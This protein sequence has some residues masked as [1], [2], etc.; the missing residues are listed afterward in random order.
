[1]LTALSHTVSTDSIRQLL[2]RAGGEFRLQ[3]VQLETRPRKLEDRILVS[4]KCVL[5]HYPLDGCTCHGKYLNV[6]SRFIACF[7]RILA[8]KA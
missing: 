1:M 4:S 7:C 5:L 6:H 8:N 2:S 3:R